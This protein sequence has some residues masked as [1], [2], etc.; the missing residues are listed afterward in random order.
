MFLSPLIFYYKLLNGTCN[1]INEN[2]G[3]YVCKTF[4]VFVRIF[5]KKANIIKFLMLASAFN[6][7]KFSSSGLQEKLKT[8]VLVYIV[9]LILWPRRRK[10][11]PKL[12]TSVV[13]LT[14]H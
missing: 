10:N 2:L 11:I 7:S 3:K 14:V 1:L 12:Y 4:F 13:Y 5:I 6:N 8:K 9:A